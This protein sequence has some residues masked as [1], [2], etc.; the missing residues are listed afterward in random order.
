MMS[1]TFLLHEVINDIVNTANSLSTSLFKL[2]YF[3]RLI[4][5][6]DLLEYTQN[7]LNGY[8]DKINLPEYRK[9]YATLYVD[10]QA[11]YNQHSVQLPASMI[12]EP[13]R[14]TL[15]YIYVTEGIATVEKLARDALKTDSD[16]RIIK[17][18]PMEMLYVLQ[19]PARKLYKTDTR[20]DV[21]GARVVANSSVVIEIPNAIRKALFDFVM[22]M[23]T[24][25]GFD[26]QI[27]SFRKMADFNNQI[28]L[29]QM[30]TT[31]HNSGDGAVI[32]TGDNNQIHAKTN[33]QKGDL[34]A[35]QKRLEEL[36]VDKEDITEISEIVQT[37]IPKG[38]NLGP[39]SSNWIGKMFAKTLSGGSKIATSAAGNLLATAVKL[40][41]GLS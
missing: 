39:K 37:E 23:S 13:F 17:Q 2:T 3:A 4:G 27:E 38:S 19:D 25:F 33:I 36:G 5:N 31:I 41:F 22:A 28:I 1:Q 11:G 14:D 18:L 30:N 20:I 9:A 8:K 35:L 26:I 7:E 16:G 21:I 34:A 15:K 10:L 6:K 40:Y 29:N 12:D 24:T 32:N